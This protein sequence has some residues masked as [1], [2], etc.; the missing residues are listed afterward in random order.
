MLAL[1]G[2][3]GVETPEDDDG[4][5]LSPSAAFDEDETEEEDRSSEIEGEVEVNDSPLGDVVL[6]SWY[7]WAM[8]R[9]HWSVRAG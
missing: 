5:R 2:S 7:C 9:C 8:S 1:A 4:E 3:D 6:E